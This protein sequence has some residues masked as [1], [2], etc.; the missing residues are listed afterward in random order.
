[1]VLPDKI[2]LNDFGGDVTA[3]IDHLYDVYEESFYRVK[4]NFRDKPVHVRAIPKES[5]MDYSFLHA[6]SNGKVEAEREWDLQRAKRISWLKPIIE[7]ADASANVIVWQN[8]R[9]RRA[10]GKKKR[11]SIHTNIFHLKE[12]FLISLHEE[13]KVWRFLSSYHVHP[14]YKREKYIRE[15]AEFM[16]TGIP[17]ETR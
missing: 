17:I 13:N 10:K 1:M 5:N 11:K 15:H 4:I 12:N 8:V 2:E 9:I 3:Y 7:G 14:D 16:K 6:T